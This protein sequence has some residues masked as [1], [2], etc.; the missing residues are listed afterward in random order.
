ME[1]LVSEDRE[2]RDTGH[3]TFSRNFKAELFVYFFYYLFVRF[4]F[5]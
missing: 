3:D 2:L 1:S 5:G 4:E